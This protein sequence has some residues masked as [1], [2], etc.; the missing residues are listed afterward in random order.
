MTR[1]QISNDVFQK[2]KTAAQIAGILGRL[3]ERDLVSSEKIETGGK[4]PTETWYANGINGVNGVLRGR[5]ASKSV[6][7]V[8]SVAG[9]RPD[10]PDAEAAA[11]RAAIQ[12][13]SEADPATT[14]GGADP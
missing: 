9:G 13:E 7:S 11:E 6:N 14:A 4:R 2:N 8:N 3:L 1:T 5:G 12:V 10:D